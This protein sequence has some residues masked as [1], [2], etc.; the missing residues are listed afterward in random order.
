MTPTASFDRVGQGSHALPELPLSQAGPDGA[1]RAPP[2]RFRRDRVLG[3]LDVR[4][5]LEPGEFLPRFL[6]PPGDV[7]QLVEHLLCN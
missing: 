6:H 7:A 5:M 1:S 2:G 3:R 4:R